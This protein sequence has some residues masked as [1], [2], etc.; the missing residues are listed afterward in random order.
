V[1][2]LGQLPSSHQA[3]DLIVCSSVLAFVD[4]YQAEV[5]ALFGHLAP[6]GLFVQW[7]WEAEAGQEEP[8]GLA[9]TEIRRTLEHVGLDSVGVGV[10]F[11]ISVDGHT[12]Q[13][14]MGSGTRPSSRR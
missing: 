12:M 13:P 11:E 3:Y 2:A 1:R 10:G 6:G 9:A 14:I 7:D 4:D 8:G 5:E